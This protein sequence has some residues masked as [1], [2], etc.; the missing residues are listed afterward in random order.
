MVDFIR[1]IYQYQFLQNAFFAGLLV[2]IACGIVGTYIVAKRLVFLSGGITHS[3]FGGIGIAYYMGL[4]P[5]VGAF[6]FSAL[7]AVGI[8]YFADK[9]KM[10]E[11]SAI[12]ILWALGTAIGVIFVS[13]TPGYAPNLMSFL[14]GGL[15]GV[16]HADLW[17]MLFLDGILLLLFTFGLRSILYVAFDKEFA[18]SQNAPV[19]LISY[20]MMILI[21]LTIVMCIRVVGI[22]LLIALLTIPVV[23]AN[24]FY[25]NFKNIMVG[26]VV[27]GFVGMLAG[28]YLSFE[29]N[30][31]S[32]AAI[33]LAQSALWL[34]CK[35]IELVAKRKYKTSV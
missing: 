28:L 25:K 8:E 33:I 12:G 24:I 13:L 5:I 1:D 10:R 17:T 35:G 4:N 21:S 32:G 15:L 29:A 26:S 23:T 18:I 3:S 20:A 31:P 2:S 30:L 34:I 9:T 14:F 11:D 22:I 16:T 27:L 6:I 7:S 19:K